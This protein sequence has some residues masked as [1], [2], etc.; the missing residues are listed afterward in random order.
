MKLIDGIVADAPA[1][2][3]LRRD[4]HAH[5]EL[6]FEEL[7][8]AALVARK[9]GEWGIPMHQGMAQTGVIGIVHGRDGGACGRAIGLRADMDALPMQEHNRFA[10]ASV[11]DGKMHAC[12]HDG[13]VAMLLAAAQHFA[14][15]RDFDGTVYLI[16]QPAEEAGGGAKVDGRRRPVRALSDGGGVRH[17]QL[18]RLPGGHAGGEPRAGDGRGQL[19]PHR[20][21]RRRQPCRGAAPRHR[22]GAGGLPAGDGLADTSSAATASPSTPPCCR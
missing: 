18:A 17:A 15:Q 14:T 3:R 12:G 21:A 19:L 10:H 11:F 2:G 4:I 7:R 22:P 6:S 5:P 16:F 8:T 1:I 9:L 20:R 13:H